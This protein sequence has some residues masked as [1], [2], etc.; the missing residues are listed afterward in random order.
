MR[1]VAKSGKIC[2]VNKEKKASDL[3]QAYASLKACRTD[4]KEVH[5]DMLI[6]LAIAAEYKEPGIGSHIMRVSDY[7]TVIARSLGLPD[8][9]IEVIRYASMMHDIGKIG[10]RDRILG[11]KTGLTSGEHKE[12]QRHALI[13][14]KI[15]AGSKYP[16]VKAAGEIALTHH[17]KY[18]GT[19]YPRGLK[20]KEIPLYGRIVALADSLDAIISKRSYKPSHTLEEAVKAIKQETN[21]FFDPKIVMAFLKAK[22]KIKETL[23]ASKTVDDFAGLIEEGG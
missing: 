12:I 18:D 14:G 21:T 5:E 7:S 4:I 1:I 10:I 22:D 3:K 11:K 13:G 19:G 2:G 8:N 15:F 23:R 9:E 17:E 6:R 20:G 16:L